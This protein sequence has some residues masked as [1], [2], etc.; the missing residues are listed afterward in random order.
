[1]VSKRGWRPSGESINDR[2]MGGLTNSDG[3]QLSRQGAADDTST[4]HQ[5]ER[6]RHS[7]VSRGCSNSDGGD[8]GDGMVAAA[9]AAAPT[10]ATT[11]TVIAAARASTAAIVS[12]NAIFVD[13]GCH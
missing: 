12:A 13:S 5:Q 10:A 4:N 2:T 11:T 9:L 7:D 6:W 3:R 1:M 8:K